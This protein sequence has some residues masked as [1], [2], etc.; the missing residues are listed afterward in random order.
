M[1]WVLIAVL[2]VLVLVGLYLVAALQRARPEA[3]PRRQ[4]LGADRRAAAAAARPDPEH[5][6][7]GEGLRRPRAR[8]VRGGHAR[9]APRRPAR[10]APAEVGAAE[11]LLSQALGRLFAVAEAYPDLKA[12]ENFLDLQAQ[13][14]R[15]REQD[16]GLAPGLQRHRADLQ[17]R[18]PGLPGR[19]ASRACSASQKREFFEIEDA[20][21]REVPAVSFQSASPRPMRRVTRRARRRARFSR[22]RSPRSRS[23]APPAPKSFTL[24]QAD[25][26]RAGGEGRH[27]ARGRAHPA[28][29]S[30]A[31]SRAAIATSRCAR[32][33]RCATCGC[34]RA[35][36]RTAPG[37][38]TELGCADPPG[39]FGVDARSA[40]RPAS[41]GTTR[42]ATRC[43]RSR[44]ATRCA[45][46]AVAYDDVV[47]VNLKV[48]GDEWDEGLGQLTATLHAPGQDRARL[49]PSGRTCAATCSSPA[50]ARCCAR[51]TCRRTSSSSC[52]R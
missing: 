18:D 52:A 15:H 20:G 9:R 24:L 19:A 11:G 8:H 43:G 21:D 29:R 25:V 12:N 48:W 40:T 32:A 50:T 27:A 1:T 23:P 30:R 26:T 31:R 51:S 39:T 28:T 14:Q 35:A 46:V 42:R 6:R 38:C 7:G 5:R 33:S 45:G 4:R 22:R 44:S 37:G 13:L 41:S 36:A 2:V 47:D 10:R 17:Q 49:G 3:Q 34:W 16:R